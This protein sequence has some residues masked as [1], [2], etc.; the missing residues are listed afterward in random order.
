[1]TP[2]HIKAYSDRVDMI[3]KDLNLGP[4]RV[5]YC[6]DVSKLLIQV[7][8]L[9]AERDA[10]L[11]ELHRIRVLADQMADA[12]GYWEDVKAEMRSEWTK[13]AGLRAKAKKE[14]KESP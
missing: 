8:I 6:Q 5:Q 9:V 12:S 1:M 11:D 4:L 10:L 13:R 3:S 7:K 2:D 14:G